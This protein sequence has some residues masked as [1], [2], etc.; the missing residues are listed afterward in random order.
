MDL[1]ELEQELSLIDVVKRAAPMAPVVEPEVDGESSKA[2]TLLLVLDI[3]DRLRVV[4]E[5]LDTI[6]QS[7]SEVLDSLEVDQ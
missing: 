5:A 2:D 1:S 6:R 4:S 3:S 7:L